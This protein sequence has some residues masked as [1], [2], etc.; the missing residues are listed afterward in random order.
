MGSPV[1]HSGSPI[2]S[3]WMLEL[4]FPLSL[5][6]VG[7]GHVSLTDTDPLT[8]PGASLSPPPPSLFAR[9][10]FLS[11]SCH[12]VTLI[13]SFIVKRH[14]AIKSVTWRYINLNLFFIIIIF[15]SF[16]VVFI[17]TASH[18]SRFR[19]FQTWFCEGGSFS[20]AFQQWHPATFF[21]LLF[22]CYICLSVCSFVKGNVCRKFSHCFF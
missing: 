16:H 10:S 20:T 4:D 17:L 13:C 19:H 6:K 2:H 22:V 1:W 14:E 21:F 5:S 11:S 3:L 7:L 18:S 12:N 8:F 9:H 15:I